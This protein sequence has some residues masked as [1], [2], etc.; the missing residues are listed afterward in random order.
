MASKKVRQPTFGAHLKALRISRG[1]TQEQL[2]ASAGTTKTTV[3]RIE[4][5]HYGTRW[6][7]AVRLAGALGVGVDRFEGAAK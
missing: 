5:G 7:L 3:Y 4:A 1:L 6:E 2:A